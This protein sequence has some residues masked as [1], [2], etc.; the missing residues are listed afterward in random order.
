M[1]WAEPGWLVLLIVAVWPLLAARTRPPLAWSSIRL[2]GVRRSW[3]SGPLRHVPVLLRGSALAC[4][5]VAMARPQSVGGQTRQVT[6]G[7][8]IVVALDRSSSMTAV[9]RSDDPAL[10]AEQVSRL[11][12]AKR[13]FAA[14]VEGR[15]DD[16]IGLVAF[17]NFPDRAAPPTLDHAFLLDAAR[18]IRPARAGEDGTN[19]G[20]ALA[21]S[22]GEL[23]GLDVPRKVVILLTDGQN[24]PAVATPP[25][26]DPEAAAR[27]AREL[28]VTLHTVAIGR[29]DGIFRQVEPVSGLDRIGRVEGPNL[30]LLGRMAELGGGRAFVAGDPGALAE[31]F[32]AID[33]LETSTIRA[34]VQVRYREEYAPWILAALAA[35]TLDR[36]ISA[37]PWRRLP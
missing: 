10:E 18:S 1:R 21:W 9:D 36:L 29:P 31:V 27:L 22:L 32:A 14:F 3:R 26:I 17:A 13:T 25:P 28:G 24:D 19:L 6:R 7:V 33:R 16:L 30:E 34:T 12:A 20:D 37:G 35:L 15:P 4:L 11:D 2:F 5:A 23:R 8:A